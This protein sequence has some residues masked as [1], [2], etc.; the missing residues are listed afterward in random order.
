[1]VTV[2]AVGGDYNAPGE[3]YSTTILNRNSATY[4]S[5]LILEET[6]SAAIRV[7]KGITIFT[8]AII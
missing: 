7:R 1:M 5:F 3:V 2:V 6:E 8:W 4:L